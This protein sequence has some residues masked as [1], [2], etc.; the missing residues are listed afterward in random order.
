LFRSVGAGMSE[1]FI[2]ACKR[3]LIRTIKMRVAEYIV[4]RTDEGR[5]CSRAE[6]AQALN[7]AL[8][9]VDVAL[10]ELV[11]LEC[12]VPHP[13]GKFEVVVKAITH[14]ADRERGEWFAP[15]LGR[16]LLPKSDGR[17]F[18][19]FQGRDYLAVKE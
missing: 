7:V 9:S 11:K 1:E 4:K 2:Y 15:A 14:M 18:N 16:H 13:S 17:E 19:R 6:I 3:P 12:Y 10:R 5:G 8:V